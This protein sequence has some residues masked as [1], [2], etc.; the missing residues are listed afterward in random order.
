MTLVVVTFKGHAT[1]PFSA[2][3]WQVLGL[4]QKCGSLDNTFGRQIL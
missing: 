3:V 4:S 2:D 1:L